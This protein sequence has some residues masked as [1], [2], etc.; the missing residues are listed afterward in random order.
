LE[1]GIVKRPSQ[2]LSDDLSRMIDSRRHL[3]L[4]M[5]C[6]LTDVLLET[7]KFFSKWLGKITLLLILLRDS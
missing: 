5:K 6:L 7:V 1:L 2:F 3:N 4:I